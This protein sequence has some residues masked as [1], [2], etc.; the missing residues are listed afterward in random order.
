MALKEGDQIE[1][2]IRA[3]KD[4][5]LIDGNV[6]GQADRIG[7]LPWAHFHDAGLKVAVYLNGVHKTECVAASTGHGAVISAK[8]RAD[9]YLEKHPEK[10]D[11][12]DTVEEKGTVAIY[13]RKADTK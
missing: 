8:R 1:G 4:G 13:I 10:P 11:E 3:L 2:D 12:I 9:G 7:F 6:I 5:V